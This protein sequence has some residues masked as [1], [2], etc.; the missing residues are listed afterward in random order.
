MMSALKDAFQAAETWPEE[1]Q[2][3]LVEAAREIEAQ[4]TGV[5]H[6]TAEEL[7]AIDQGLADARQGR[8]ASDEAVAAMKASGGVLRESRDLLRC[9]T[10]QRTNSWYCASFNLRQ[11]A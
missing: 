1:D 10:E 4:R 5:Y 9:L 8:F 11:S 7:A 6:A 3:A 2:E